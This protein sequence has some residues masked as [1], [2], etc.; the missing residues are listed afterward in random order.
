M[1]SMERIIV[2]TAFAAFV[3]LGATAARAQVAEPPAGQGDM[4]RDQTRD[5][6]HDR[7][8]DAQ[9]LTDQQRQRMHQNLNACLEMNL[10]APMLE[11]LFPEAGGAPMSGEDMIG[12]QER[13]MTAARDGMPVEPML[14]KIQEGR[15]KGVPA[16]VLQRA[17]D[18]MN[19]CLHAADRIMRQSRENGIAPPDDPA[20]R[21][22]VHQDMAMQVWRGITEDGYGELREQARLRLRDGTCDMSDLAAA[23]ETATRLQEEGVDPH[24]AVRVVGDALRRGYRSQDMAQLQHMVVNR[25]RA[26]RTLDGFMGDMEYCLGTGMQAGQMYN[27]MMQHGWMGPG[28]M[29]GPW[30][31]QDM[32]NVGGPGHHGGGGSDDG[33]HHGGQQSGDG[34]HGGK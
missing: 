27:Y 7:I 21:R 9:H 23:G 4:T 6:I 24:R 18:R 10:P 20:Q 33:G 3:G 12:L 15:T 19:E 31:S 1:R 8:N 16:P 2:V 32:D 34:H 30:G 25:Q 26:G 29:N 28:H 14:A 17:C 13:V 11:G 5:R 22:R